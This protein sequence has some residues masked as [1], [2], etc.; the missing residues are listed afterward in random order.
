MTS[1]LLVEEYEGDI[2]ATELEKYLLQASRHIDTLTYNRIVGKTDKLTDFQ[3]DI[4]KEVCRRL[5]D[6]EYENSEI[7]NSVLKSYSIN[8]VSAEFGGM[9]VKSINNVYIP[10]ELYQLLCQTGLCCRTI[11][12]YL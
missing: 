1:Y 12:R 2:P 7:L 3:R 5:A 11:G 4:I 8:G 9:N 6:W 10:G